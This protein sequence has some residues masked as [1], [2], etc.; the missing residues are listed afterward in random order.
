MKYECNDILRKQEKK[1]FK[2]L[3]IHNVGY[4]TDPEKL[5]I[6]HI[7]TRNYEDSEGKKKQYF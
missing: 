7:R 3:M 5:K 4:S 1:R 2:K 6:L